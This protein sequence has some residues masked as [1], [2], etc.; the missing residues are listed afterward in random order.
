M[1]PS[2][3]KRAEANIAKMRTRD[4]VQALGKLT[5]IVD[6]ERRIISV[7][8]LIEAL[9]D[10]LEG[11][12]R[13]QMMDTLRALV[14]GYRRTLQSDRR[15]LIEDFRVG[16]VARKVVGVGS[17]GTRAWILLMFGRDDNDPLFLQAKEAQPSVLE[18]FL[19]PSRHASSAERVV[20]GQHLMQA[21]SDIFLGYER[22]IGWDGVQRDFYVRQLRDWKGSALVE[23]M[24]PPTM[25]I[26]AT[27]CGRTLARA[28]AR[29]GDRIAIASYLGGSDAFDHA[30]A[31]FSEAYADQNERDYD[32][33][34][35]AEKTGRIS[36]QRGL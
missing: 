24:A 12:E 18:E 9:E 35:Q 15:H 21:N 10:L 19:G 34:V 6:G 8:P 29:A 22:I 33:L 11:A 5:E 32:D 26:Y 3:R 2:A 17:V 13:D 20:H 23:A 14:H 1:K 30:I 16:H 28:H 4:S 25:A 7:P 27:L 36:A 31:E